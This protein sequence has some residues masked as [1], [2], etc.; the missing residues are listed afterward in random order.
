MRWIPGV[1]GLV[2]LNSCSTLTVPGQGSAVD[3]Q[4]AAEQILTRSARETGDPWNRLRTLTVSYEGEWSGVA[5]RLQPVLVDAGYRKSSV[6][7]YETAGGRI[8]QIHRGPEGEKKVVRTPGGARVSYSGGRV[9]SGEDEAAAALVADAY[10]I[11][12]FGSSWLA[13]HADD[14]RVLAPRSLGGEECDRIQGLLRP[15]IGISEEDR[16]IAWIGRE[17]GRMHRIQF[18]I[19]GLESTRGADVEVTFSDFQR[20]PDGVESPRRFIEHV[21]R[22]LNVKAHEWR[23]V[24]RESTR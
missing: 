4:A 21:V 8:E 2:V 6:E 22:P 23:M 19:D 18:T 7:R 24:E 1:L 10:R 20:F 14:P 11:F 13:G 12:S 3:G 5:R 16:F 17:T 15:G 9:A